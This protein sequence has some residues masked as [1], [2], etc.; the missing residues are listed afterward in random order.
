[1]LTIGFRLVSFREVKKMMGSRK[2]IRKAKHF[3]KNFGI[4]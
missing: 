2:C 1:M 4:L 3:G